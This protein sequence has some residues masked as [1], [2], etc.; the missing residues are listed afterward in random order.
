MA[1]KLCHG[2]CKLLCSIAFSLSYQNLSLHTLA[3][4]W[5]TPPPVA[6]VWKCWVHWCQ[7]Q[8]HSDGV[9]HLQPQ[10]Q[11]TVP[12]LISYQGNGS[13]NL[14]ELQ[15]HSCGRGWAHAEL[16]WHG[17]VPVCEMSSFSIGPPE[18]PS[19]F[20]VRETNPEI[21]FRPQPRQTNQKGLLSSAI[22]NSVY[23]QPV[24]EQYSSKW[25]RGMLTWPQNRSF[26][27]K[28]KQNPGSL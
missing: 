11:N 16:T 7:A 23:S 15:L 20:Y 13:T 22:G 28:S 2:P 12:P 4:G 10:A 21:F 18:T 14:C 5:L 17:C 6:Q 8:W 9:G 26:S 19:F 25:Y 1:K 24:S 3:G 27:V